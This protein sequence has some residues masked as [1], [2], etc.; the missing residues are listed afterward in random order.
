MRWDT[1]VNSIIL[2]LAIIYLPEQPLQ[3]FIIFAVAAFL[4]ALI[5][6]VHK[7]VPYTRVF[8]NPAKEHRPFTKELRSFVTALSVAAAGAAFSLDNLPD[9]LLAL[10]RA[11]LTFLGG[12]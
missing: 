7:L 6:K 2:L 4:I 9:K 12:H 10:W 3:R 8:L 11:I 1:I 5:W